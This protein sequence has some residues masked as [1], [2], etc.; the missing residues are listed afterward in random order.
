MFA[1]IEHHLRALFCWHSLASAKSMKLLF[2][3]KFESDTSEDSETSAFPLQLPPVEHT[4]AAPREGQNDQ[5]RAEAQLCSDQ[6]P[7]DIWD[8]HGKGVTP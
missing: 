1:R 8:D 4:I 3:A 6:R 5:R 7:A 2:L